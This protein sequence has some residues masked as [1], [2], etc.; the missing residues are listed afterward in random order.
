MGLS[1]LMVI[2]LEHGS[3]DPPMARG[4]GGEAPNSEK[5]DS[6]LLKVHGKQLREGLSYFFASRL[7]WVPLNV[8][9]V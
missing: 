9:A 4:G 5:E 8:A 1:T 3:V 7:L 6:R 2:P